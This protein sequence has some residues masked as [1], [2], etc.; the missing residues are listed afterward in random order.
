MDPHEHTASPK[1]GVGTA[2]WLLRET[3]QFPLHA[4]VEGGFIHLLPCARVFSEVSTARDQ[5]P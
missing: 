5:N 1:C 2:L 3:Q 4:N